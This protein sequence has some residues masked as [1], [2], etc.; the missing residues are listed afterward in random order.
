MYLL[1][2]LAQLL[3][4]YTGQRGHNSKPVATLPHAA[5]TITLHYIV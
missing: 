5:E 2:Q 1:G 4:S 3:H